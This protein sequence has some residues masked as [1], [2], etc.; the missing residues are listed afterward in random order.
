MHKSSKKYKVNQRIPNLDLSKVSIEDSDEEEDLDKLIEGAI[1]K[2]LQ[3]NPE[4][5]NEFETIEEFKK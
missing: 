3:E 5:A 4:I 2:E 1:E